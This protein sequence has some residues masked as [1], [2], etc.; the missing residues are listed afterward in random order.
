MWFIEQPFHVCVNWFIFI[1]IINIYSFF[2]VLLLFFH[3]YFN[4]GSWLFVL[5]VFNAGGNL[6]FRWNGEW[7]LVSRS[8]STFVNEI[9]YLL[10]LPFHFTVAH[11]GNGTM[12]HASSCF[13]DGFRDGKDGGWWL[14]V[15]GWGRLKERGK[16][17]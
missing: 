7:R 17:I 10:L 9:L 13:T 11:G 12:R 2:F 14:W 3:L 1:T 5:T 15:W 4:P 16:K 6:V 8:K